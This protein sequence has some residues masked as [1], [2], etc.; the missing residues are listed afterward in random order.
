MDSFIPIS[1]FGQ[2]KRTEE[3][4]CFHSDENVRRIGQL[5]SD[6]TLMQEW[7]RKEKAQRWVVACEDIYPFTVS[8]LAIAGAGRTIIMPPNFLE[9]TLEGLACYYDEIMNIERFDDITA[10]GEKRAEV[11]SIMTPSRSA[12]LELFTSGTT[13]EPQRVK[14]TIAQLED[15][16]R[17]LEDVFGQRVADCFVL[18]TVPHYHIYGLLFR[19]LWPL[20]AGRPIVEEICALPQEIHE[21]L[22]KV[23]RGVLVSSPAYLSRLHQL[24]DLGIYCDG[25]PCIFSSGGPLAREDAMGIRELMGRAPV[26]VL[27]STE[28]GGVAWRER[29]GKPAGDEWTV[30]PGVSVKAGPAGQLAVR[31]LFTGGNELF[32]GDSV[33][34]VGEDRFRLGGR[35]DRIVKLQEKRVS[36]VE[37]EEYICRHS[38]VTNAAAVLLEGSRPT[39]GVAVV[40]K[41]PAAVSDQVG[42]IEMKEQLIS[43]MKKR[44][45]ATTI[46]RRWRFV[47]DL[48]IDE[49]GKI[50]AAEVE[51]VILD[52]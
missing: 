36:L 15:E 48:P 52:S 10:N 47:N 33:E 14:K 12:V 20:S 16:T 8:L 34:M 27:G 46:P 4:I 26:E 31:S 6:I 49:R 1:E 45:E 42:R 5:M 13:G 30:L 40:L 24:M 50:T 21:R 39:I 44:F 32:M 9:A 22:R 28:T 2:D 29:D 3:T 37:I 43:H 38:A 25:L 19:V 41:D 17:V 18:G 35:L 23:G 7:L 51:K 11:K